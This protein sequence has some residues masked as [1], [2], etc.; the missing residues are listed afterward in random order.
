MPLP[1]IGYPTLGHA[2][3]LGNQLWEIAGTV[4]IARTRRGRPLFPPEWPYRPFF[5]CPDEWFGTIPPSVAP[6]WVYATRLDQRCRAYLQ[7]LSLW[8]AIQPEIRRCFQPSPLAQEVVDQE[9][10]QH[11]DHLPRP[12][13]AIHVRRGDYV[14]NPEGTITALPPHYY[15]VALEGMEGSRVVFSDDIPWCQE[16]VPADLYYEGI[17]RPKEQADDYM[18]APILDW[19]DLFLQAKCDHHVI[20]NSTY[21]WWGAWLSTNTEARYPSRWFGHEL[22]SYINFRSMIPDSW[23]EIQC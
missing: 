23:L 18:T 9:W 17:P 4:G 12:I 1:I 10:T 5:S 22:A 6:S 7:D 20:S 16:N 8:K 21:S 19:V 14:T 11:L 15:E 13:V 2:G 3:R